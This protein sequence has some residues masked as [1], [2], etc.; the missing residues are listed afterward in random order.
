VQQVEI[1]PPDFVTQPSEVGA[2]IPSLTD[3]LSLLGLDPD[4]VDCTRR[5]TAVAER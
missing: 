3:D 1:V 2:R 4:A 5:R